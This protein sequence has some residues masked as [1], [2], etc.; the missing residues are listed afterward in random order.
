MSKLLGYVCGLVCVFTPIVLVSQVA[1]AQTT[2]GPYK[3][4]MSSENSLCNY[5]AKIYNADAK[6][7]GS[8]QYDKHRIFNHI[9]W[10]W[11]PRTKKFP[12]FTP[13]FR[14]AIFDIR[15]DGK[16][17]LVLQTDLMLNGI[18]GIH[19][20][21]YSPDSDILTR[22]DSNKHVLPDEKK[23]GIFAG[24]SEYFL[25]DVP[26]SSEQWVKA[27]EHRYVSQAKWTYGYIKNRGGKPWGLEPFLDTHY[28]DIQP[29]RWHGVNYLSMTQV[30]SRWLV[31]S[32]FAQPGQLHDICYLYTTTPNPY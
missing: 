6:S 18:D 23:H 30:G 8:I 31:I 32:K 5:M 13:T 22:V 24:A 21:V 7:Y 9:P 2:T 19:I 28:L 16:K 1:K 17:E 4:L 27:Y 26:R 15:N 3:V 10:S 12:I 29:F 14:R 20:Y 11:Q 25:K